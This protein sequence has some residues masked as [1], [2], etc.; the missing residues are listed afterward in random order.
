MLTILVFLTACGR[1]DLEDVDDISS[2]DIKVDVSYAIERNIDTVDSSKSLRFV[3]TLVD[4]EEKN[5]FGNS[6]TGVEILQEGKFILTVNEQLI[7]L[8]NYKK[9]SEELFGDF[10]YEVTVDNVTSIT[11]PISISLNHGDLIAVEFLL[12]NLL[13]IESNV[14]STF[15]P[16]LDTA[17]FSWNIDNMDVVAFYRNRTNDVALDCGAIEYE[18]PELVQNL[19]IA[20]GTLC[21]KNDQGRFK[22]KSD[23]QELEVLSNDFYGKDYDFFSN[24]HFNQYY[25][26]RVNIK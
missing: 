21:H 12:P 16:A 15:Y 20:A 25:Q 23:R 4:T 26:Q 8:V 2:I 18:I 24:F 5:A 10:T 13:V 3:V 14:S 11:G 17:D 1:K 22:L 7:D 19:S 9:D 6:D